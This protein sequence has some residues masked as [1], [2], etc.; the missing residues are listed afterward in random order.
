[1]DTKV[2]KAQDGE[3]IE[4]PKKLNYAQDFGISFR[5]LIFST[6]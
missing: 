3:K 1:M 2:K 4:N 6:L 5:K